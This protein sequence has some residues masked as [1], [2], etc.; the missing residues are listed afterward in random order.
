M[1]TSSRQCVPSLLRLT[2]VSKE[3]MASAG[4]NAIRVLCGAVR[5]VSY[6][7]GSDVL[8]FYRCDCVQHCKAYS[9]MP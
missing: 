3:V 4:D 2:Y 1:L 9:A 7:D 5:I 6:R 8:D